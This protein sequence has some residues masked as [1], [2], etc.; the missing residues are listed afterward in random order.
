MNQRRSFFTM[1]AAAVVLSGSLTAVAQDTRQ[2]EPSFDVTLQL[3]IGSNDAA[4]R[5]DLPASLNRASQQLKTMMPF[6]N[7]RLAATFLGRVSNTGNFEYKSLSNI[8]DDASD[9]RSQTFTDWS[10]VDL[11]NVS[12]S[13]NGNGFHARAFRFGAR[14]PVTT[15]TIT[16]K[17]GKTVPVVN[18]EAI[19]LN[20]SKVGVPD[21]TPTLIG[22]LSLPG[23]NDTIFLLMTV[24]PASL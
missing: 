24:K 13:Q 19:G 6:T 14:V 20:L 5:S 11:R 2:V 1:L 23:A 8:F 18:Y 7:Y 17:D 15:G 22:T 9:R 4:K 12:G 21:N 10:L 16:D 3:V